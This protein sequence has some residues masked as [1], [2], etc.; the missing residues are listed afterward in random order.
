M[1]EGDI[2]LRR[3]IT[4]IL[5]I[6]R[7]RP[8]YTA[9]IIL[10]SVF[11]ALL[12]G[13]GIGFIVPIL[14]VA[15]S[16]PAAVESGGINGAFVRLYQILGIPFTL[17]F[18]FG[19]VAVVLTLRYVATFIGTWFRERLRA[20]YMRDLK[21][22]GFRRT[23]DAEV[24]Y[25][26]TEG[27]DDI[28]NAIITQTKYAG[29]AIR[30]IVQ[31]FQQSLLA[32]VYFGI[33]FALV[34]VL[35]VGTGV[36]LGGLTIL[37]RHGFESGYSVGDAVAD[38]NERIQTAVQAGT[39]GVRDVKLFGMSEELFDQFEGAVTQFEDAIIRRSRNEYGLR[40]LQ[41]LVS[42]ISVFALA[43]V[44]LRF[45]SL[46]LSTLAVFLFAMFRL[47]PRASSLNK[48][49][50]QI[51]G[52][53]PHFVRTEEFVDELESREEPTGGTEPVPDSVDRVDFE[54]VTFAYDTGERVLDGF[55]F[56][57]ESGEFVAFVGQ[58]GAGKST[59]V[60]LLARF[61]D[62]DE[63]AITANGTPIDEFPLR[64][65]RSK[66]AVV[67][68]D[69]FIFNDTLRYNL[70]VADT[71]VSEE[72]LRR[73]C[74]T[75]AVTEFLDDL[76][77]GY[78]TVLGDDGVQLSGGQRQ[79]V[80]IARALLKDADVL[81]MDEATSDLDTAIEQEVQDAIES[82]SRDYALITIAHRLSTVKGADRIYTVEDGDIT[83]S[84]THDELLEN[85]GKYTELYA[86]QSRAE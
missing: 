34:P 74:E 33:A 57:V 68:Q 70:T 66:I 41:D 45:A 7:Y 19:G 83:E 32:L 61:Y 49:L 54:D 8:R 51:E 36:F 9:T 82:M 29:R 72:R 59:V 77:E 16:G 1:G 86:A 10:F 22:R 20:N 84:G 63:G 4:S 78:D 2:S 65:W 18:I 79:R 44:A 73:V 55:S 46:D 42:A 48:Y 6:M 5:A 80:A 58:S 30:R 21:T 15:Q 69:P 13:I 26:D 67:R 71:A 47:A 3:K 60:S 64:E 62:P 37:I 31:F 35:T 76:P 40:N 17:E 52:D 38:A 81:I 14:S 27:S 11:A 56:H 85:E 28:L 24:G 12:E 75:A 53:L 39:Q 23:L 25:F 43:Y 50:Y